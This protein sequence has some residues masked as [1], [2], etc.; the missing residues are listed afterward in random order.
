M[1][2]PTA[3]DIVVAISD[4]VATVTLN[5]PE[6]RNAVKFGMWADL[7]ELYHRFAADDGVRAVIMTGAGEHFCAGADITE[8]ATTRN[9]T[10]AGHAYDR[11]VD[12]CSDAI[13]H[14]PKPTI[15]AISGFCIGG[16]SG[17]ALANDFRF[18]APSAVFAI[19]AATPAP[20]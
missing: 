12:E 7:A 6:R 19:T 17:L 2:Y 20:L 8:F 13:M 3:G 14:L 9:T 18:A 1:S 5:R 10:E 15:A 4:K 11:I 16:G